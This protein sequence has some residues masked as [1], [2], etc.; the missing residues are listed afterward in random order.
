MTGEFQVGAWYW[1]SD[2]CRWKVKAVFSNMVLA[3]HAW[4]PLT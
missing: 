2:G 3:R 4:R 1:A